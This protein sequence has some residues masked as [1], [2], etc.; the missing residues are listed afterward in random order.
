MNRTFVVLV[1]LA[2][3]CTCV[4]GQSRLLDDFRSLEGWKPITSD[5]VTMS[6]K[7]APGDVGK[8]M[9]IHFEFHGGSGY[10]IAEKAI[11]LDLPD[12]YQFTFHYRGNTPVNNFEFKLIDS[13]GNVFWIKELNIHYPKTWTKKRIRKGDITFAWGPSGG[14][15][16]RKVDSIQFVVSAGTG[17]KGTIYIDDFRIR[18]LVPDSVPLPNPIVSA[19]SYQGKHTPA[20]AIDDNKS[21]S[22][23]SSGKSGKEWFQIDRQQ[24]RDFGGLTISWNDKAFATHYVVELSDDGTDWT[25]GYEVRHGNG[26]TDYIYLPEAEAR[27][28]RLYFLK[29][30]D[31]DKYS[32][33]EVAIHGPEFGTSLNAF[34]DSVAQAVP[35]GYYP[36]YF[37]N[38]QS[39]WT[40]IGVNGDSKK[41]L[42]NEQGQ[43]EVDISRFSIEPFLF[44]NDS[45]LTWHSF[46]S[47]QSLAQNYLPIPSV[48]W[49]RDSIQV[50]ITG[51]AEGKAGSSVLIAR[52][53]VRNISS[54]RLRGRFFVAIRPF[55]VNPPWQF[56][57]NPGGVCDISNINYNGET[58]GVD[59]KQIV[60]LTKP[61]WFGAVGFDSGDITEYLSRGIVPG[62]ESVHDYFKHAS[63]A[64][65]YDLDIPPGGEKEVCIA[66]PFHKTSPDY[67]P[68]M[69]GVDSFVERKLASTEKYWESKLNKVDIEL[70]GAE[71]DIMN[72]VKSNLA[73]IF[74]NRNGPAIQPGSRSYD[75]SWIRDGALTSAALLRFGDTKEVREF[76]DWYAKYL[77]PNGKV[78]C[79]VDSRG[80]DPVPENDSEG[81]FIYAVIQYFQFTHDTTW[82][83]GKFPEVVKVVRYIQSLRSQR[84]TDEYR[85]G[86]PEQ[87]ACYGLMPESISHEGYSNHPEH[88]YW[89][90]FF[91]LRG[92]KDATLIAEILGETTL[93]NEFAAERDDFRRCLYSSIR[94]AIRNNKID[95]I[96]GCV[97]LGDFDATS[98]TIGIDPGDELGNIPE[99]Q[100]R[101]TFDKYYKFFEERKRNKIPWEA[102]TPYETRII[103]TFVHLGDRDKAQELTNYFMHDRRPA[104]WN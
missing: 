74:I 18:R 58:V 53:L 45:L 44:L 46:Q 61:Q 57:N 11:P 104:A 16:I 63:A 72:T 91:T 42:M 103:G 35:V 9:A 22:W 100:L 83:R 49:Q 39:Y 95:Y 66:V 89:D 90:D 5:G 31:K 19:S 86:T 6:I 98:T 17:G 29:S 56:L 12:N 40:L 68:N 85:N 51:F 55:Q 38:K 30:N 93:E 25:K 73:Y 101:N 71:Q 15:T 1:F 32:I 47:T 24:V 8:S 65:L 82:L 88:S 84:M 23:E 79:V 62:A 33:S 36:K 37:T 94:L 64:L 54:K 59:D 92:L 3:S 20:F 28:V 87:R 80:A 7:S 52:Y 77:Y 69:A 99:P 60:P 4:L 27:Y 34:F 76:I 75:R 81:E 41:A 102:Y 13:L 10:A 2:S 48:N 67:T 96:P 14:G 97:E 70:P 21:T 43:I 26:G 50:D 78:P